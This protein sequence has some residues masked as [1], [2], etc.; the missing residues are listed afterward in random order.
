MKSLQAS[1][2]PVRTGVAFIFWPW[3]W[4]PGL[5]P[6]RPTWRCGRER[7]DKRTLRAEGGCARSRDRRE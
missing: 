4:R 6:V 2:P 1:N 3:R 7:D 5:R